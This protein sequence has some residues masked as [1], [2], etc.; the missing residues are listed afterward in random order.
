MKK[1]TLLLAFATI[2]FGFNVNAQITTYPYSEDF[3]SGDGGWVADN[4]T[5]GT[6]ALGTPISAVINSAASGA[7]SW[8]T[9]LNGNYNN[10][11]SSTVTSPVF[12]FSALAAPAISFSIW[13]ESENSWDGTVLQSS[14]D[15]GTTWV[16]VGALG[17]AGNW[18]NDGTINGNPG[19]QQIG[20]TGRDGGGS[21]GWV[22]ANNALAGLAGQSSV[23]LR[24]AFGSDGSVP[25]E[26]VA[27][28]DVSV[29]NVTCPS[30][31]GLTAT[32]LGE[33][34]ADVSWVAG[35]GTAWEIVVQ[36]AGTGTPAD[37][38]TGVSTT[39][40]MPYNV[41]SL[42]PS[43]AYEAYV[44]TNCTG[45]DGNSIWVGPINFT[46]LNT[47]PP[48][49]LGVSC[50]SGTSST[51]FTETFGDAPNVDPLG[52]TGTGFDGSNGNWR[53]T[54]PG[55]NSGGTGPANSFDGNAGVHLEYEASGNASAIASA[56]SP[57]IDLTTAVDGAELAFLMHAF[58]ED[59]GTLNVNVGTSATGPFT[60]EYTWVGSYQAT[61]AEAWVPIGVNLDAYL[62]QVV[63]LE[64]SYGATGNDWEG[65]MALDQITVETCGN[66][67][68]APS[69]IV[70][71]NITDTTAD[72]SWIAN[73]G[74]TQW[75]YVVQPAG[76]GTPTGAGTVTTT[77]PTLVTTL[78]SSTVY[79]FY[80]LADCGSGQSQY[81]GPVN[82]TTLNT[83]PPAPV[84]VS[85]A[86]G[87]SSTIY[88][89][90][91][92][93]AANVDPAGWT[94]TGF[95]G[96]NGNWR[97]TNAGGNSGGTGPA[98]SFDGNTGAHLEYEAS[99][100][101]SD[102]ASAISPAIDLTTAT[103]G[104]ELAFF[105]HAFGEDIGT[106]NVNVGTSATGPFTTE[107]TWIGDYQSTDAEAW[108]PIGINLDAYLGQV[109]YL[110]FSYGAT[111]IGF[112]GDI[113]L[114][115]ITVET[116][117]S[118]CIAP[119]NIVAINI[120]DTTADVSW[121]ANS[122]ETQWEYVIQPAGTG[123][124][125]GPG[126]VTNTPGFMATGLSGLAAYEVYVLADCGGTQSVWAGPYNF[127][128]DVQLNFAVD[129]AVGPQ[130][131]NYCYDS[132]DTNVFTFTSTDGSALN[133]TINSGNVESCCDELVVYDT[134]GTELFNDT[135]GGDLGGLT[136]QSTGDTISFTIASDG[137]ISCQSSTT[138]NPLD[139][140]VSCATCI[141][142]TATYQ[143]V[144]DCA[145]GDQF[146][147]DVDVTSLGDATS[148]SIEDN[149]GNPA[150]SVSATG[151]TQFGPYPFNVD[152]IFTVSNDQ[153]VNCI[154]TSS[155]LQLAA[156]PPSN[157]N[158]GNATVA[159]VNDSFLCE[160]STPGTLLEATPSGVPNPTC[161]GDT[162]DDVW[163]Q[164]VATSEFQ[165]IA[166]A[167]I[168][169]S[170]TFNIDH[171]LYE[172][173]CGTLVEIACTDA[174][175]ASVTPALTI[176]N[177][178]YIRIFSGG[179]NAETTT[180]DICI[181]P[182]EAPANITC[183]T[184]E[185]LCPGGD[186][187]Y[188][189]NTIGIT[190]GLGSIDCLGSSP[191]PTF[192]IVEIGTSGDIDIEMVQNTAFDALGNPIGDE[193]DVDYAVWGPFSAGDD[194]CSG[195]DYPSTPVFACSYSAAAVE[196]FII[197]G[198]VA[199]DIYIVLI[200]NFDQDPG[201][202][203]I[204]QTN[205]DPNNPDPNAGTL[206]GEIEVD[207]ISADAV[208]IDEDND[209]T[210]P[211]I[212]NLCGFDSIVLEADSPFADAYEWYVNGI[213]D[214]TLTSSSI[215][216]TESNTYA[217]TA[218]DN[219]CMGN[220]TKTV[221]V[222]LYQ[223]ATVN[224]VPQDEVSITTCDDES[225]D[226]VEDF[227]LNG[228][229][230]IILNAPGQDPNDFLVTYHATLNDAQTGNNALV[231][232]YSAADGTIIFVRVED[233]DSVGSGSGCASTNTS[234]EL[235]VLG[236]LP[237]ITG[238]NDLELCD[239]ESRDG[240]EEF[241]L[242]Q[243]TSVVLNG[244]DPTVFVVTYHASQADADAGVNA[245]VSPYSNTSSTQTIFVRIQNNAA[246]DCY[247]TTTFNIIVKDVP[248]TTFDAGTVYEVCPNANAPIIL[249]P[250]ADNY[251]ESEVT[252]QWFYEGVV[253]PGETGL[254]LDT[255]LL[256]GDY[257]IMVTFNA[258]GA[259]CTSTEE[260]TVY[261]LESCVIPQGISPNGDGLNDTFDLSSFDVQILTIFNRNG[262]K[263][264]EKTNYTN[265]WYGQSSDG[266]ELPVGTYYYV[267]DYQGNKSK[268]AWV[269]VNRENK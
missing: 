158:C 124:P 131:I 180:F 142:P 116:C 182:Y 111:G 161:G 263:V 224:I 242:E 196:N 6:W 164:F 157:D 190:P 32:T 179:S 205:L 170:N 230:S 132:N 47:P 2:L 60:T 81:F 89:E 56:I 80:I 245:L 159:V 203:Q 134:D 149:Q 74:E 212:A 234:F 208:F 160:V 138:I 112:E 71:A 37:T 4:A 126:T 128:T 73:N 252:I 45:A 136:F 55:G 85:C 122:G 25:D 103:D 114:D 258:A 194:Y 244:Q 166:L 235:V 231:S 155:A 249:A 68:I 238:V 21:N 254:T 100:N 35:I 175:L 75:E 267:M 5:N 192:S 130:N 120:T 46:T 11:E 189:F 57:A 30:P 51:I 229:S 243:N 70:V 162:D 28:D 153:D 50:A 246:S 102:I 176:G 3:E 140:T 101:A 167:N 54:N 117:G 97:I 121:T 145:N 65:D 23:I 201:I 133:F 92:G 36:A 215:T 226:G 7:N 193:L 148:V 223:S 18:Y 82:F 144:D 87:T 264:Y 113:A 76:T 222:N 227:N 41:T 143:V 200:T 42:T 125:T 156:C 247:K 15:G 79:E 187:L 171:A 61:D 12:D 99:G 174:E 152:V 33:S 150:V 123:A 241:N 259:Q 210:T 13:W 104:A 44:R 207:I 14:I 84:G 213:L 48:A 129:C 218:Y 94:G 233:V 98:N 108:V 199:G 119:S 52:W 198:A 240:V 137:S 62:G 202:I 251:T 173:D 225:G 163:F 78:T 106:L 232:P 261:E 220:D 118:F 151:I 269:Y 236:A 53:I 266:D 178:Y 10:S 146:L 20:W 83:P 72:V 221:V 265:E 66:F 24:F 248:S 139:I 26:G 253:I 105:M 64:F 185:N 186:D 168:Q 69:N 188:T 154:I 90:T 27:F 197:T 49:P 29:F 38:D 110:E 107:Y 31:T 177:T 191:N 257:E 109:V 268:A 34:T 1:I 17:D 141:N 209:E 88:T 219:Q 260:V 96:S 93:D 135:N 19:G 147:V 237:D 256:A 262:V 211:S 39:N 239:D 95:D 181:T 8:A 214:T 67:C 250:T 63:Y 204:N 228:L 77:N 217:V 195:G 40:N 43:T 206:S 86:S 16:N 172:G 255:V 22:T 59:I 58:G 216:V 183:D 9:N 184:T 91:F 127:N 165:L 115:Q 169:G